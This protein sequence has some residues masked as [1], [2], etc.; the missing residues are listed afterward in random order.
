MEIKMINSYQSYFGYT[1]AKLGERFAI[2]C[3]KVQIKADSHICDLS[4]WII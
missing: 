3:E 2:D 1:L 4:K